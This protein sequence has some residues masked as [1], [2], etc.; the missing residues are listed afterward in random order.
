MVG[1]TCTGHS[2]TAVVKGESV[3]LTIRSKLRSVFSFIALLSSSIFFLIS[4][5]RYELGS[6]GVASL[7]YSSFLWLSPLSSWLVPDWFSSCYNHNLI[8]WFCRV[9]SSMLAVSVWICRANV[10]ESWKVLGFIWTCEWNGTM[11]SN[12]STKISSPQTAPS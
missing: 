1:E 5:R 9:S 4:L 8:S 2:K 10:A 11:F 6:C 7:R 12:L 3:F